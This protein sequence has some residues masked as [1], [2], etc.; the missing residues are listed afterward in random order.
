MSKVFTAPNAVIF[1]DGKKAG[2]ITNIT[3][4]ET[5]QRASI[6]GLG[7]T[8]DE[9]VPVVGGSG[10]W[11]AGEFFIDFS[12]PGTQAWLNRIAATSEVMLNSLSLGEFPF[13]IAIYEKTV[14]DVD[15]AARLVTGIDPTGNRKVLLKECYVDSQNFTISNDGAASMNTSGRYLKP[16]SLSK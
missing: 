16:M 15:A 12:A 5:Y 3:F 2:R 10:S 8:F 1:I 13:T 9:E 14:T 6:K 4:T 11:Q 7:S